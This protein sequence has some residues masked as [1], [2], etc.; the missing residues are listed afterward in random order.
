MCQQV[1][2][3]ALLAATSMGLSVGSTGRGRRRDKGWQY[4]GAYAT[5]VDDLSHRGTKLLH[6]GH[7]MGHFL[8]R[9]SLAATKQKY[10]R[11]TSV[12]GLVHL[13]NVMALMCAQ[14][15]ND[16]S[17]SC[18]LSMTNSRWDGRTLTE[19]LCSELLQASLRRVDLF[20]ERQG[21]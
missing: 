3:Q 1:I 4:T 8:V 10:V 19:L 9:I 20:V 5:D 21:F 17:R 12:W 6:V 11:A 15:C 18:R 7:L 16:I 13:S 14:P 2:N